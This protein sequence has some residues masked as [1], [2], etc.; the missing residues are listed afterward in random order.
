MTNTEIIIT[1][2]ATI[3]AGAGGLLATIRYIIKASRASQQAFLDYIE[4]K[5]GHMERI[6]TR[7]ADTSD[8]LAK[9]IGELTIH[10]EGLSKVKKKR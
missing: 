10:I 5:N 7:F 4:Q 3:I 2:L 8:V 9:K 6:A 1:G